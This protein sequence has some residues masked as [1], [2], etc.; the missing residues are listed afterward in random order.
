V[1]YR[2]AGITRETLYSAREG[3]VFAVARTLLL[4]CSL[5][6]LVGYLAAPPRMDWASLPLSTWLRWVGIVLAVAGLGLV[7]WVLR[8][9]GHNFSTTLSI[10]RDQTLV[11]HGPYRWVRHP[12]YSAFVLLWVAFSLASTSWLVGLTGLAA[13]ALVMAVR[14]PREER[15]LTERFG[16]EY[17]AYMGRTGRFLPRVSR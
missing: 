17:R 4:G 10:K 13:F 14:T 11:T 5:A 15:M 8:A 6:A 3:A 16:D 12:M 2:A 9:L 1:N 7:T